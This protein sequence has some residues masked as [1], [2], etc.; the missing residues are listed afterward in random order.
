MDEL[1]S[2][3]SEDGVGSQAYKSSCCNGGCSVQSLV[4]N[5]PIHNNYLE[6]PNLPDVVIFRALVA[7]GIAL[8][9]LTPTTDIAAGTH[10]QTTDVTLTG[11]MSRS[12]V[13]HG[14]TR[15]HALTRH[16]TFRFAL[17]HHWKHLPRFLK[18]SPRILFSLEGDDWRRRSHGDVSSL[19]QLIHERI[20]EEIMHDIDTLGD[21]EDRL[22]RESGIEACGA[23]ISVQLT[24]LLP[25]AESLRNFSMHPCTHRQP[26]SHPASLLTEEDVRDLQ[27]LYANL[28]RIFMREGAKV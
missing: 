19:E 21:F 18:P 15:S 5:I 3:E 1:H 25:R 20:E 14:Q 28:R 16:S 7:K 8:V 17:S 10:P 11:V 6:K 13:M 9:Y 12:I 23:R 24:A 26:W 22:A 27:E 2:S 4:L